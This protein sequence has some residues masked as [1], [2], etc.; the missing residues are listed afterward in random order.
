M[1][2]VRSLWE[3]KVFRTF[4][5]ID[6]D[7]VGYNVNHGTIETPPI[8]ILNV[9]KYININEYGDFSTSPPCEHFRGDLDIDMNSL[10][11]ERSNSFSF[12]L[13]SAFRFNPESAK[14]EEEQFKF[15][16]SHAHAFINYKNT[17][18]LS[19]P[20][21][22]IVSD[23][24]YAGFASNSHNMRPR[25]FKTFSHSLESTKQEDS[26]LTDINNLLEDPPL[27]PI[28]LKGYSSLTKYKLMS[29]ELADD[30]RNL[31]PTRMQLYGGWRLVYSLEQ[32][33]ASLRTLYDNCTP[34]QG[35]NPGYIIA[36]EDQQGNIFG[37]YS[38]VPPHPTYT[39]RFTGNGSCFVW[40]TKLVNT[41][42]HQHESDTIECPTQ[43]LPK[44]LQ[45]KAFPHTGINAGILY[46]TQT[47][48]AMGVSGG[49]YALMID[50]NLEK[51]QSFPTETFG[52]E[53]LS[54]A[55]NRFNIVGV[56]VWRV[57]KD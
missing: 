38:N 1:P 9:N 12:S 11:P 31:L 20:T 6:L 36:I 22:H 50:G 13:L 54:D 29:T 41:H 4:R 55:G 57:G 33:G 49:H 8:L 34:P 16:N 26:N 5:Y 52:N 39:A 23:S 32:H 53:G 42:Q 45:F 51:G 24:I 18:S 10:Y 28:V 35:E 21:T 47:S 37:A 19:T 14:S 40:K 44:H 56:E 27:D 43:K 15:K 17:R 48:L 46:C 3:K 2:N 25:L 30:L 7:G